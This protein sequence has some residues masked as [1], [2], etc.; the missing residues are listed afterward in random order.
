MLAPRPASRRRRAVGSPGRSP[1]YAWLPSY[2]LPASCRPRTGCRGRSRGRARRAPPLPSRRGPR[3]LAVRDGPAGARRSRAPPGRRSCSRTTPAS[4]TT[5]TTSG[6][7]PDR[8]RALTDA[9]LRRFWRACAAIVAPV[10]RPGRRDPRAHARPPDRGPRHPDRHRRRGHPRHWPV[11]SA[12]GAGWP[13][14]ALV[15]ASLGRLAPEKSVY[16]VLGGVA[17]AARRRPDARLLVIG[18]GPSE[19]ALEA[20]AAAPD[21]GRTRRLAGRAA[22]PRGAG[23]RR[24][25]RPVRLRVADRDAGPR[26]GRGA[27]GRAARGRGR[28][29]G[30]AGLGP[31]RGRRP[32]RPADRRRTRAAVSVGRWRTWSRTRGGAPPW[33]TGRG[34]RGPLLGGRRVDE[35]EALYR[36]ARRSR[37]R[38][39][40]ACAAMGAAYNAGH[41]SESGGPLRLPPDHRLRLRPP[42]GAPVAARP[43][44]STRTVYHR[45]RRSVVGRRASPRCAPRRAASASRR[46]AAPPAC[47]RRRPALPLRAAARPSRVAAGGWPSCEPRAPRRPVVSSIATVDGRSRSRSSIGAAPP[48]GRCRR[49]RPTPARRSRR[50]PS[51]RRARRPASRSRSSAA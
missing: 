6:R 44:A 27:G 36:L 43:W 47:P 9:Y 45:P 22:A 21:L 20:R 35:T 16:A 4:P 7:S 39:D 46:S 1:R 19:A 49:A 48:C 38:R 41:A 8:G 32:D 33:R 5:A 18:G 31:R 37:R 14:D 24:R 29:P 25:R 28:R 42:F 2:Q 34:G 12:P 40:S 17:V 10:E 15:V 11:D 50:P 51:A 30:G 26:A 23:G 3:A 13:A